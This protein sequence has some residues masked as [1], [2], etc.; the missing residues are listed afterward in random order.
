VLKKKKEEEGREEGEGKRQKKSKKINQV[1]LYL[2]PDRNF[3]FSRFD[4]GWCI[5]FFFFFFHG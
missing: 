4:S 3:I 1:C 5:F 2:N